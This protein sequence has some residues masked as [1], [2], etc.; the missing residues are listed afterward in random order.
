[1]S[2]HTPKSTQNDRETYRTANTTVRIEPGPA[3]VLARIERDGR[4][5]YAGPL[6][7]DTVD[8]LRE[9]AGRA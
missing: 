1:M 3:G 7:D 9:V 6:D 5:E 2:V 4:V 8:A